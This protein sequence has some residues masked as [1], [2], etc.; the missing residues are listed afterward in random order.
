MPH[1]SKILDNDQSQ[2]LIISDGNSEY[3]T[4]L[5]VEAKILVSFLSYEDNIYRFHRKE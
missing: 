1:T 3:K 2:L 4:K 5:H